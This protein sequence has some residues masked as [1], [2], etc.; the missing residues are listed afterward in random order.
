MNIT[1]WMGR[2]W[3]LGSS[4]RVASILKWRAVFP[5]D[6]AGCPGVLSVGFFMPLAR[7][8]PKGRS[9]SGKEGRRERETEGQGLGRLMS[10][11]TL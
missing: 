5:Y 11:V 4:V 10:P 6:A 3:L 2:T 8:C 7:K 9:E 1:A